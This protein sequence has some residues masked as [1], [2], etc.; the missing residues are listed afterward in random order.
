[1][2]AIIRFSI[3]L[4][5]ILAS[6]TTTNAQQ[7]HIK[8][9]F[10]EVP[11]NMAES[12][13]KIPGFTNGVTSV[14]AP[15][16]ARTLLKALES[17]HGSETLAEPEVVTISGRQTQMRATTI[18]NVV[19]NFAFREIGTNRTITPQ[20]ENV[21]CG[22]VLDTI[23]NVLS[24][25]YTIDLRTTASLTKFLGYDQPPTNAVGESGENSNVHLP[26]VLPSL[27]IRQAS[28][29]L[30][31]WDGQ[32]VVLGK[33][34]KH[35]YDGGKEVSAEPDYFVKTKRNRGQENE[36]DKEVLVFITVTLVDLA[37]NRIHPDN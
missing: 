31:L 33:L 37:G 15:E 18:I 36:E 23:P 7:I 22:P 28:A 27:C 17:I 10:V 13:E 3:P 34:E 4:V 19:T 11:K 16:D 14:L 9:R 20:L 24:D 29:D 6:L 35:F 21:E 25:G 32:T 26:V 2:K 1:M 5:A 30:K 12:L 8:S